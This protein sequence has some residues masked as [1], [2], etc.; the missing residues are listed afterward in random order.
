VPRKP[1]SVAIYLEVG[2]KRTFASA[3]D[4]PGWSRGGRSE[5][6][7]IAALASYGDRYNAV[8]RSAAPKFTP[9][10]DASTFKVVKRLKGNAG[11]DFGVPSLGLPSDSEPIV[12]VE[13]ERLA[14][15]LEACWHAFD[16]AAKSA[17]GLELRKGPRGGG[18]DLDKMAAHVVEADQAYMAQLGARPPK[19]AAG[20]PIKSSDLHDAMLAAFRARGRGLVV[21]DPRDTKKPWTPRYFARRVGWHVLDHA[22]EIEDRAIRS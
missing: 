11:T 12:A 5:Q 20:R 8:V 15:I 10:I 3:V 13:L 6:E 21:A 16:R 4:W 7:A 17:K 2:A 22:W 1:E 14:R 9:P 18:R 19:A